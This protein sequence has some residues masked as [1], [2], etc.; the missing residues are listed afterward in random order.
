MGNEQLKTIL[1]VEDE[2]IIAIAQK[3]SL[4]K[5]GYKIITSNSGERALDLFKGDDTIDLILMDIDLGKGLDGPETAK[6]ILAEREIPVV[7]LSSHTEP[8]IVEKTEKI[9]SYGYVVKNS[10]I[11][12]LDASIKMAFKLFDVNKKIMDSEHRYL[13]LFN[14]MTEGF[15]LHDII[16]DENGHPCDYRFLDVNSAF[17]QLTGLKRENI[18][19]KY[20]SQVIPDEDPFWLGIYSKVALTGESVHLEHY[21]SALQKYYG[22]FAYTPAPG[23]FAVIFSDITIRRQAENALKEREERF[24]SIVENSAAGYFF[25]DSDGYFRNVNAA[26]MRMHKYDSPEEI[27]GHHFSETQVDADKITAGEN[28]KRLLN[29][30]VLTYGEFSHRC[31][32]GSIAW[33]IFSVNPVWQDGKVIGMEGFLIDTT[34]RKL[35]EEELKAKNEELEALNGELNAAMEEMEAANEELIAASEDL[36]SKEKDLLSE[37]I[38]TEALLESIPG[39]L[40]VYDDQGNLIRWNKKH[41]EMTGYS[42]EELSHMNMS[43]WF[44]GDDAL[45]VAAAVE[46]VFR[47]GYGEVEA[48]LLIKGGGKIL[49]RSNGVRLI[50][51]DKV[52]FT[53]VGIDITEARRAE[54]EILDQKNLLDSIIESTSEAIFAKDN[55]GKYRIINES[56]ARMIGRKREEV[57]GRTDY[58]LLSAET[59]DEFRKTDEYVLS[60]GDV[61]KREET[62]S[63]DGKIYTFLAHKSPWRDNSGQIIGVIGISNDITGRKRIE[64]DLTKS[65]R[66]LE[67]MLQTMVDGMVTVDIAG[68]IIYSNQAAGKILSIGKDVLGR[69]YQSREWR[70]IDFNGDPYPKEQL[71]LA[72]AMREQRA[73]VNVEHQII[74]SDGE[75]KCLS[76]NAAP[77]FDD[78]GKLTGGIASFRDITADK[79]MEKELRESNEYLENLFNYANAPIIV[80]DPQFKITRFNHAFEAITGRTVAEVTGKPL[81]ILFPPEQVESSMELIR[82]T[83]EGVK[84]TMMNGIRQPFLLQ[85]D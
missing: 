29:G 47:T 9:T 69:N 56:G 11:T 7:F 76:V 6:A 39:Y 75:I 2:A 13:S 80:W 64:D 22:V 34:D 79:L 53:G 31:K 8:E 33:H 20:Q 42:A 49:I 28:V 32:D 25:I 66:T 78:Q 74:A 51:D 50:I 19:G 52:Y 14:G 4:E 17:E 10:G 83:L 38:F 81:E 40:Y 71:P 55:D 15:A 3:M 36:Q 23:Q 82:K 1:L 70:Q 73:V 57:I 61:Y 48:N 67:T 44:E 18:L 26:W 85:M 62:G 60:T 77:L 65:E 46:E 72:I 24:R 30:E 21:S 41:E 68:K 35:A 63:I 45:R 27:L 12:V 54:K 59:A 58:E 16:F 5:C 84:G 37:K 43:D